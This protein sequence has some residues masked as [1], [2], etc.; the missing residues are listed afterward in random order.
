VPGG[1]AV[2]ALAP[3]GAGPLALVGVQSRGAALVGARGGGAALV[4]AD[5]EGEGGPLVELPE[6]FDGPGARLAWDATGRR[7]WRARGRA[8][9][10]LE[11]PPS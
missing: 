9:M 11:P 1:E 10:A 2:L 4:R 5:G 3:P 6:A 8:L 7:L